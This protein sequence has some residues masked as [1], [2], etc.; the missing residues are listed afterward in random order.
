LIEDR[1]LFFAEFNFKSVEF[2]MEELGGSLV[3][4][5]WV[6]KNEKVMGKLGQVP[7]RLLRRFGHLFWL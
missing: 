6:S 3:S 4:T 1:H 7:E 5:A 2:G